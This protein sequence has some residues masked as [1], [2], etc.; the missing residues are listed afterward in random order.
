MPKS[1]QGV[2]SQRYQVIPRS[3]IFIT[4]KDRVLLLK[5]AAHKRL[6]ANKYNGI[7]GHVELGENIYQGAQ[8]ELK[9]EAGLDVR[10]LWLCGSIMIDAGETTGIHLFVFKGQY[11]GGTPRA[12]TEGELEWIPIDKIQDYPLVEDL[13]VIVPEILKQE[14]GQM[15]YAH[16]HYDDLDQL[17]IKYQVV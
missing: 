11:Q 12:S 7:G 10:P 4:D 6:W 14:A 9:E 17:K 2:N 16:Y 3:L 13:K 1:E 5:G 8:R 15:L